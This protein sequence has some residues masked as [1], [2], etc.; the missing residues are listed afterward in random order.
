[1]LEVTERNE[2]QQLRENRPAAIHG[3]A[4]F[5][6]EI[7]NDTALKAA[8]DFKSPESRI[9]SKPASLLDYSEVDLKIY[10]TDV[11]STI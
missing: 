2:I 8:R 10:R 5:A 4:S 6:K 11:G 7:G 1:M 3:A 9:T